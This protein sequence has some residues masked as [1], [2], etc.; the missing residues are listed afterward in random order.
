MGERGEC[1]A[2]SL[3]QHDRAR[4]L[5]GGHRG[6]GIDLRFRAIKTNIGDSVNVVI[7]VE[8]RPGRRYISEVLEIDGYNPDADLFD[9]CAIFQKE[10]A[11][12]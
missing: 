2:A 4:A 3:H 8:R 11:K 9:L 5:P 1:P 10:E 7:H 12:Q 6:F